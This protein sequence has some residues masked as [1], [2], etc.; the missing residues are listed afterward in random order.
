MKTVDIVQFKV[1]NKT[2]NG[3][4]FVESIV[5]PD[6]CSPISRQRTKFA[7]T[8][9]EHLKNLLYISDFVDNDVPTQVRYRPKLVGSQVGSTRVGFTTNID[10]SWYI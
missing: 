10:P 1:Q 5:V 7:K 8:K 6:I 3:C 2:G 4:V 9:Y